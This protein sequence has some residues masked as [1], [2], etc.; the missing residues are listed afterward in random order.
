MKTI[1]L[2]F[3]FKSLNGEDINQDKAYIVL[4]NLLSLKTQ[5]IDSLK[6]WDW[7]CHLYK[8][9]SISLDSSDIEK[10]CSFIESNESLINLAK[11]Q[12]IE[13]IKS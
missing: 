8:E 12:L 11:A 4:S 7:A 5:G 1:N 6:A 2:D 10:L 13:A 3:S 9:K